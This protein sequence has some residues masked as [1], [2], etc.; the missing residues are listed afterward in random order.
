[1]FADYLLHPDHVVPASELLAAQVEVGH[2]TVAKLFME[3]YAVLRQILIFCLDEGDAGIHVK[4]ALS[5]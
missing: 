4:D 3:A 2:T 5:L 1:M